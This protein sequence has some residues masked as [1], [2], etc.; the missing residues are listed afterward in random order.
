MKTPQELARM[1]DAGV[2]DEL[3][4][5]CLRYGAMLADA[6]DPGSLTRWRFVWQPE[7]WY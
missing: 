6:E 2:M 5:E 1:F 3:A 4:R 7:S